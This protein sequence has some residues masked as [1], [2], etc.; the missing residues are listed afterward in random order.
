MES[1]TDAGQELGPQI[2]KAFFTV[3]DSGTLVVTEDT[4][5]PEGMNFAPDEEFPTIVQEP[6]IDASAV[7]STVPAM[8]VMIPPNRQV[9]VIEPASPQGLALPGVAWLLIFVNYFHR[10][11]SRSNSAVNQ[12][13]VYNWAKYT[14]EVGG[15]PRN[16]TRKPDH[17]GNMWEVL[18]ATDDLLVI[19]KTPQEAKLKAAETAL[20]DIRNRVSG[21]LRDYFNWKRKLPQRIKEGAEP[22]SIKEAQE[23]VQNLREELDVM[24]LRYDEAY[25]FLSSATKTEYRVPVESLDN[26]TMYDMSLEVYPSPVYARPPQ[27]IQWPDL[28]SDD[29]N[30]NAQ[31]EREMLRVG[32]LR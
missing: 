18:P 17:H 15:L 2:S 6:G 8:P 28:D 21:V 31:M 11:A 16:L 23:V 3:V 20:A 5:P 30:P 13:S 32:A 9:T 24:K 19:T 7:S 25:G 12:D 27:P 4:T 22:H 29:F 1:I 10:Y 14:M 26:F